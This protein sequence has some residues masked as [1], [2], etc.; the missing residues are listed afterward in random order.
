MRVPRWKYLPRA[1]LIK[2]DLCWGYHPAITANL[3]TYRWSIDDE[4]KCLD[5]TNK[6]QGVILHLH[7]LC[8][9]RTVLYIYIYIRLLWLEIRYQARDGPQS[10]V[11]GC[12]AT[13]RDRCGRLPPDRWRPPVVTGVMI[14]SD[15]YSWQEQTCL[16]DNIKLLCI[17]W[18]SLIVRKSSYLKC[19]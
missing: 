16:R 1:L 9:D 19:Y 14:Q 15:V 3:C 18:N 6:I 12:I 8:S 17:R 4:R 7:I 13:S 5:P 10:V 2:L 11:R